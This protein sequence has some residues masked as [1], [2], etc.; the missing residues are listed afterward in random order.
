MSVIARSLVPGPGV[1]FG[2]IECKPKTK[3]LEHK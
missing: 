1:S 2:F 3:Q